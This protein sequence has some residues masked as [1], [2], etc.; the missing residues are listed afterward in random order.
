MKRECLHIGDYQYVI[1]HYDAFD[2]MYFEPTYKSF[3]MIRNFSIMNEVVNDSDIYFIESE[4]FDQY[5]EILYNGEDNDVLVFPTPQNTTTGFSTSYKDFN[6]NFFNNSMY[7]IDENKKV[8][9]GQDV[10]RLYDYNLETN[11][12]QVDKKIRCDKIR[13]Y[14]PSV[15]TSIDGIID[16]TNYMNNINFHYICR[17]L[18]SYKTNSEKMFKVNNVSYCEYTEVLVP[19]INDLFRHT[20][21]KYNTYYLEDLSICG[22]ADSETNELFINSI[23][24]D[25]DNHQYLPLQLLLQPSI[26]DTDIEDDEIIYIK[27]YVNKDKTLQSNFLAIPFNV[28]LFP[29]SSVD[30]T[31]SRY[32]FDEDLE[33][34]SVSFINDM[35]FNLES[36]LGFDD[37]VISIIT[38]MTYPLKDMFDD[39][40]SDY[41]HPDGLTFN[42]VSALS[43]AYQMLNDVTQDDY[44]DIIIERYRQLYNDNYSSREDILG[45]INT[46]SDVHDEI[47]DEE[48]EEEYG[49]PFGFVGFRFRI[50]SDTGFK[51]VIYDIK[52]SIQ[53]NDLDKCAFHINGILT[54]WN[55]LPDTLVAIAE[56]ID[57]YHGY[58]LMSNQV[59]ITKEWFKYMINDIDN[60]S[61]L[62]L[63]DSND[64]M[65]EISLE[66]NNINF[67]NN[68][69][70]I[71]NKKDETSKDA[72]SKVMST[73]QK[74]LYK[75]IFYRTQDLQTIKLRNGVSQNIG[76]NLANYM[77]K[78][79][80]FK[81]YLDGVQYVETGRNDIYVIFKI[82]ATSLSDTSGT[83]NILTQDDEYI[84]SG[85]WSVY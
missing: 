45:T 20:S 39:S 50:A 17:R 76:V 65:K 59:I 4:L 57:V 77:T 6:G 21:E 28:T 31:S 68:I 52:R 51:H 22:I 7:I 10:Y 12:M 69:T 85:N 43:M 33:S 37:H 70:C 9:D 54:K 32:M 66:D 27:K 29:Y 62:E 81:L 84:S 49:V 71:I 11:T 14:H 35:K 82:N 41:V 67:I 63:N 58:D 40:F 2:D 38:N 34:S 78:V 80:T 48:Y 60:T 13:I 23:I 30:E 44:D 74:I 1:E 47:Y 64:N 24:K 8:K 18:K 56:F 25:I 72:T 55:E 83:Y 53:I 73:T 5:K 61:L 46:D 19:N 36:S 42:P 75:P 15:K 16:V 79:E 3:V 26:I